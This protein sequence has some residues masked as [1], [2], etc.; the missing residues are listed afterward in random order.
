VEI[1]KHISVLGVFVS[2]LH[3][4]RFEMS[5]Q[6][7][8]TP[9]W[10][11]IGGVGKE[12]ADTAVEILGSG[13]PPQAVGGVKPQWGGIGGVGKEAAETA[14]EILSSGVSPQAVGGGVQP[15]W[16]GIGGVGKEASA[17]TPEEK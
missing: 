12:A 17:I 16:G 7:G 10:G 11:G 4:R 6:K 9:Q 1:R 14:V 5:E 8:V 13:V 3:E 15:Q 2:L